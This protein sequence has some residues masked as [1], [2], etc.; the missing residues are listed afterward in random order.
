VHV[1]PGLPFK[2]FILPTVYLH[3]LYDSHKKQQLL[4]STAF[5]NSP[6]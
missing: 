1:P 5:N 2:L 6:F 3:V 4:P